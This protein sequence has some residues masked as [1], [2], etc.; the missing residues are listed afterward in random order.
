M[1]TSGRI[2]K[3][4]RAWLRLLLSR[5]RAKA[6]VWRNEMLGAMEK[7]IAAAKVAAP[8]RGVVDGI[9]LRTLPKY[10][11]FK[12]ALLKEKVTMQ[13][14]ALAASAAFLVYFAAS[15]LEIFRLY[16][17][18]RS[19][20]YI[21]APGVVDLTPA[22]PRSVPDSYVEHAVV[23]FLSELGN[24]NATNIDEQYGALASFM[25][26]G[27][28]VRFEADASDWKARV[29]ESGLTE[30]MTILSRRIEAGSDGRYRVKADVKTDS[31]VKSEFIGTRAEVIEMELTLVPPADGKRWFLQITG[32]VRRSD[33]AANAL[34][35]MKKGGTHE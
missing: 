25:S 29:K 34:I 19:K 14:L 9:D 20:E 7:G 22:S 23:D 30:A 35:E 10:V 18:L 17:A 27:L 8:P 6:Q 21:L 12:A 16:E 4:T 5:A 32:L 3:L 1:S 31:Y 11:S 13:R 24:I 2:L 15:R 28:K 33:Q 26:P